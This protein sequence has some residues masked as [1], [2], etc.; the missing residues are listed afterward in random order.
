MQ[1]N[2]VA[3]PASLIASAMLISAPA[4]AQVTH[5]NPGFSNTQ[6]VIGGAGEGCVISG[7][8]LNNG[9]SCNKAEAPMAAPAPMPA[10]T[11]KSPSAPAPA[12][13]PAPMAARQEMA[14]LKADKLFDTGKHVVKNPADV[15]NV[16]GQVK[17]LKAYTAVEVIGHADY[18][19]SDKSNQRL[20]ER[21]ALA[22]SRILVQNG[23][24]TAKIRATGL[25]ES[26]P[27]VGEAACKGKKGAALSACLEPD[28]RV[29]INVVGGMR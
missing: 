1:K 5:I 12:P 8:P 29:T 18:R 21:R 23:I 26:Q 9:F 7:Q 22:V 4:F 11:A 16:A 15:A 10:P 17:A 13:D 28:R 20:S 14:N 19:G 27:V 24:P 25:G 2:F 6:G 3:I